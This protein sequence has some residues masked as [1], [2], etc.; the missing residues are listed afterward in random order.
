MA[1]FGIAALGAF[2]GLNPAMGWLFAVALGQQEGRSGAVLRALP[3]IA[4]GHLLAVA[5]VVLT[6]RA[7]GAVLP[8]DAVRRL[9][10]VLLVLFALW[11]LVR[12][13]G[14]ARWVGM[15]LRARDLT[16]WSLLMATAHGAGLMLLPAVLGTAPQTFPSV[17]AHHHHAAVDGFGP[18]VLLAVHTAGM[19]GA[20]GAAAVAAHWLLG[21]GFLRRRWV[22]LDLVW[23][24]A[25]LIAGASLVLR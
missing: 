10:G 11:L 25:L 1:L 17:A 3:P 15:R 6:A 4:L 14:H 8:L 16:L 7:L 12:G 18:V 22:N 20:M 2:H 19:I 5:A 21:L 24:L 13:S 9:G 23:I